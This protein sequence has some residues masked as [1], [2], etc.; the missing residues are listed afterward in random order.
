ME[1]SSDDF[2][3]DEEIQQEEQKGLSLTEVN[4][5]VRE[6]EKMEKKERKKNAN[7]NNNVGEVLLDPEVLSK[8]KISQSQL[9]K[10]KP[11]KERSEKQIESAKR[12]VD[13]RRQKMEKEKA[14]KLQVAET[15]AYKKK[16]KPEPESES[17]SEEE[18]KPRKTKGFQAK[19]PI[20]IDE[21]ED[22]VKEKVEKLNHINSMLNNP[23][24]CQI[25]KARGIKI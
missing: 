18:V 15:R 3:S 23:F 17:E 22:E 24:Y 14:L 10:L 20:L 19:K 7:R 25:M 11:K 2:T 21:V 16:P 9:K 13:L 6:Y 8:I 4:N 1:S 12:L 5:M